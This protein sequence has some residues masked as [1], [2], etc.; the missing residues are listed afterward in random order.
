AFSNGG[1]LLASFG[2]DNQLC[3]WDFWNARPLV[4][5]PGVEMSYLDC[6][7]FSPG[8]RTLALQ[9]PGDRLGRWLVEEARECRTFPDRRGR[10]DSFWDAGL[11][12]DGR[13]LAQARG[14]EVYLT[15]VETGREAGRL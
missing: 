6:L 10:T 15:D 4:A 7:R 8:D 5:V 13:V 12:S 11:S 3:L 14:E 9:A 1:N 2:W